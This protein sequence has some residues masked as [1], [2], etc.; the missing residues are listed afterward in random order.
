MI[1]A[2]EEVANRIRVTDFR[3][4]V[5]ALSLQGKTGGS[6]AETLSNLSNVIRARKALRLKARSLSAE[7]KVSAMI[8]AALPF[9]VGGLMYIMNRELMAVLFTD[10]RGKFMVGVAVMSLIV[11]LISMAVMIKRAVR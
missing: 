2:L 5:V 11:G 6:L 1:D 10:Q 3:F 4:M 7:A 9:I 8:L